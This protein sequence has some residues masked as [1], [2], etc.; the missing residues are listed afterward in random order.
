MQPNRL[1]Y[2]GE[3]LTIKQWSIKTGL[4][5]SCINT[6]IMYDWSVEKILTTP[7]RKK[8]KV[9]WKLDNRALTK[10]N[11]EDVEPL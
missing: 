7:A 10:R 9:K 5:V 8:I 3:T 2:N 1:T 11:K 4:T 6:R